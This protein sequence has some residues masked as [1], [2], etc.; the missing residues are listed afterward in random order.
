[1]AAYIGALGGI[2]L[3]QGRIV[4]Q[5]YGIDGEWRA[6]QAA[7]ADAGCALPP[8]AA[9]SATLDFR[10]APTV[11]LGGGGFSFSLTF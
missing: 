9:P 11:T 6:Y 2:V 5:P 10:A 1:M 8:S 7:H 3:G 4:I